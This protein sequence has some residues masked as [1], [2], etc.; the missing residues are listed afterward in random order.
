MVKETK[1]FKAN[2]E[3][4]VLDEKE[5][6]IRAKVTKVEGSAATVVYNSENRSYPL[7]NVFKCGERMPFKA[8]DAP[9]TDPIRIKFVPGSSLKD[10]KA[11]NI[12]K[13]S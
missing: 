1:T 9:A 2:E 3:V 10:V 4:D 12:G 5:C 6:F 13:F 8:C 11:K 7:T